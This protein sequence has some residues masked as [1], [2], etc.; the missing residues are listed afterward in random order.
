MRTSWPARTRSAGPTPWVALAFVLAGMGVVAPAATADGVWEFAPITRSLFHGRYEFT[1]EATLAFYALEDRFPVENTIRVETNE[2]PLVP[3]VDFAHDPL[4]NTLEFTPPLPS[5]TR[6]VVTYKRIDLGLDRVTTFDLFS[7]PPGAS[8]PEEPTSVP[9]PAPFAS[10]HG[11]TDVGLLDVRGYK[12]IGVSAGNKRSFAPDQSLHLRMDGEILPGLHVSAAL[13]DQQTPIQPEGTTADLSRLDQVLIRLEGHGVSATLG[14]DDAGLDGPELVL[15]DRAMQG[16]AASYTS[17]VGSVQVVV[18][19]PK[20]FAASERVVGIEGQSEYRMTAN[21]RFV[22]M[23]AGSEKVWLNGV[24]MTR[25]EG[26]D[27]VIRE[28]GDPVVEFTTRHLITRNDIIRVDFDYIP[29]NEGWQRNLYAMR[30]GVRF[31]DSLGELGISYATESDDRSR[32]FAS[33]SADDIGFLRAGLTETPDGRA[34][35]APLKREVYGID[36]LLTPFEGATLGGEVAFHRLNANTYAANSAV[37]EGVAWRL[38]GNVDGAAG[39]LDLRGRYFDASYEPIGG[40]GQGRTRVDYADSFADDGYGDAILG[41]GYAADLAPERPAEGNYEVEG[42]LT[43]HSALSATAT[44][45]V[46]TEDFVD[47]ANDTANRNIGGTLSWSPSSLPSLRGR[48]RETAVTTGGRD[49]FRKSDDVLETSASWRALTGTASYRRF[50]SEDLDIADGANRNRR[51]NTQ[52]YSLGSAIGTRLSAALRL[53]REDESGREPVFAAEDLAIGFGEWEDTSRARTI[54][55]DLTARPSD[56]SDTAVTFARRRLER[57]RDTDQ[58]DVTS[59]VASVEANVTPFR[60][61]L[62]FGV[63]YALDKRLSSRR[64][65]IYTNV[66]LIDDAAVQL[67]PGQGSYVKIDEFHYVPD[68]D[69]GDYIRVQRTVGDTPVTA[70]E[71]QFRAR[72]DPS[73]LLGEPARGPARGPAG[74]EGDDP[75]APSVVRRVLTAISGDMRWNVTEEQEDA[76]LGDLVALRGL[77]SDGTVFGQQLVQYR[78]NV[79]PGRSVIADVERT[80]RRTLNQ[81]VNNLHRRFDSD[82]NRLRIRWAPGE[83]WSFELA[84]EGGE[85]DETLRSMA[86]SDAE[87][88]ENAE[89]KLISRLRRDEVEQSITTRLRIGGQLTV[90]LRL[91]REQET[92]EELADAASVGVTNVDAVEFLG[93]WLAVGRGRADVTYR[94][95][96]GGSEGE[97]PPLSSYRFYPGFSH[98]VTARADYRVQSFTDITFRLNYRM[99]ATQDRPTE[100]RFDLELVAEL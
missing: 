12:T 41:S 90:G 20:G 27:Y 78:V 30:G 82:M 73:R 52:T 84:R 72:L 76:T 4:A 79:T 32:P 57:L 91:N 33:L 54:G 59:N 46:T 29:E 63:R 28:Y 95:A 88:E 50:A 5:G 51:Q 7:I 89:P 3:G 85:S 24:R 22:A 67:Q 49:S 87:S 94:L 83:R 68:T 17:D 15:F 77:L 62:D 40:S 18:A 75:P 48:R 11:A 53:E 36:T 64:E 26:S 86:P 42:E 93:T 92:A 21:G 71:A 70:V 65:E 56:W 66:V 97:L 23:V 100:H 96:D 38:A 43:P 35:T 6:V 98:E 47:D 34:L 2:I 25:G 16:L 37:D 99:L 1:T 9:A 44:V 10:Q 14:D 19:L 31:L 74:D 81:R 80:E 8:T 39:R 45:G 55:V 69:E 61:A 60:R 13:S 58:G